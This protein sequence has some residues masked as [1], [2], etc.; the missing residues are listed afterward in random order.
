MRVTLGPGSTGTL[1][2]DTWRHKRQCCS[3]RHVREEEGGQDIKVAWP[4][5]QAW[6]IIN[7]LQE[8]VLARL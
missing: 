4:E 5:V 6:L 8:D 1:P 7:S 2:E 3:F